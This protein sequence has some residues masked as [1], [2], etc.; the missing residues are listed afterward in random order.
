MQLPNRTF[1]PRF[2]IVEPA[3]GVGVVELGS[4]EKENENQNE[5]KR[6]TF[7]LTDLIWPNQSY[8]V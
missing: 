4:I 6:K 3:W 7:N 5:G 8:P 1:R 2:G